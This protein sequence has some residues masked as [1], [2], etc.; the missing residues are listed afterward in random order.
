M[1]G[2][3]S[4][5][6][7]INKNLKIV[8]IS[9]ILFFVANFIS[10]EI[11]YFSEI[12]KIKFV[13][14]YY[15]SIIISHACTIILQLILVKMYSNNVIES[16][17]MKLGEK[18]LKQLLVGTVIGILMGSIAFLVLR[19]IKII[20]FKGIS[21][22]CYTNIIIGFFV[23]IIVGIVEEINFRGIVLNQLMQFKGEVFA[24]IISSILFGLPH[25]QYYGCPIMLCSTFIFGAAAG[26]LYIITKSLYLS[27]GLHSAI[28]FSFFA[29]REI[30]I[31]NKTVS[32]VKLESYLGCIQ[33]ATLLPILIFIVINRIKYY[34][35]KSLHKCTKSS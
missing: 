2:E 33:I 10:N 28:D 21:S 19:L 18:S 12:Y 6:I 25:F 3:S 1:S 16:V 7:M 24:I 27:I 20:E 15:V 17:G 34:A 29:A 31:L 26:G 23:A 30:F 13:E 8:L 5:K 14:N 4:K 9:L 32:S 11:T 22:V 35:A